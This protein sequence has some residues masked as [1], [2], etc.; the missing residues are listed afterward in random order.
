MG[1]L[2]RGVFVGPGRGAR[3]RGVAWFLGAGGRGGYTASGQAGSGYRGAGSSRFK[4]CN[5][6]EFYCVNKCI[7]KKTAK[8]VSVFVKVNK[9]NLRGG[10]G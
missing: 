1:R 4:F 8:I 2:E 7:K 10:G 6:R 3:A 9:D 5:E